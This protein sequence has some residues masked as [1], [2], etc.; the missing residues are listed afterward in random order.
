MSPTSTPTL[1]T[2]LVIFTEAYDATPTERAESIAILEST[3]FE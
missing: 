2:R 3:R 1:V